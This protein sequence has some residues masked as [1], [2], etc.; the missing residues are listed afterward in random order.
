M[1]ISVIVLRGGV[2]YVDN[3]Y[4]QMRTAMSVAK[5][6]SKRYPAAIVYCASSDRTM[7]L[8]QTMTA[9]D[10]RITVI[11]VRYCGKVVTSDATIPDELWDKFN[12]KR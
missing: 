2:S 3:G 11:S 10:G 8:V 4:G 12:E 1:K 7:R 9:K 5:E 6:E